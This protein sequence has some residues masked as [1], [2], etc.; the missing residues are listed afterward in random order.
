MLKI[1]SNGKETL[2]N[3][4]NAIRNIMEIISNMKDIICNIKKFIWNQM[5][6]LGIASHSEKVTISSNIM[7]VIRNSKNTTKNITEHSMMPPVTLKIIKENI[8]CD[9]ENG[10]TKKR[11]F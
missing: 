4:I 3:I 5:R 10:Y 8:K 7:E 2:R 1:P 6:P 9:D 11:T